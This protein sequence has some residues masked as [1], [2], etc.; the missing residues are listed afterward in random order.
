MTE[1]PFMILSQS[2]GKA[3]SYMLS[4]ILLFNKADS[5]TTKMLEQ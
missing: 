5:Y 2:V 3:R 1:V 4:T